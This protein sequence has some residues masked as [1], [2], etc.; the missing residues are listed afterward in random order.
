MNSY[1]LSVLI[2]LRIVIKIF[3]VISI[4]WEFVGVSNWKLYIISAFANCKYTG[5]NKANFKEE[6]TMH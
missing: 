1:K 5:S 2:A 4:I 3:S 6:T